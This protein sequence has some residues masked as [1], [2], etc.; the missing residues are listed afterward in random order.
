VSVPVSATNTGRLVWD[1]TSDPP[2]YFSYHWLSAAGDRVVSFEGTRTPFEEP[3][4]PG[5]R[6]TL[7]AIVRAPQ[8]P[9]RYRLVWDVVQEGRLWFSTEPGAA[10]FAS[11]AEVTGVA[12]PHALRTVPLPKVTV[13]PGRLT[14]WRAAVAMFRAH[15]LVGVGPDNFRL[16]YGAYAGIA[17]PDPR[18][19]SNN[20]YLEILAGTGLVG[21]A[22]FA[23]LLWRVGRAVDAAN[24]GAVC[25]LAAIAIHGVVD[26]F[27]SFAPTY[28]LFAVT[29]GL[30]CAHPRETEI[31]SHAH[32]V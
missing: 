18:T 11:Q 12:G 6:V 20:M 24:L 21:A 10:S 9:G 28:V 1:S 16:A 25:A 7:A 13:R 17:T 26:S 27:V 32:R 3:V 23:W 14:L 22:A 2:F 8:Q 31:G 5:E 19:H 4:R 29:L 30:A 15:P